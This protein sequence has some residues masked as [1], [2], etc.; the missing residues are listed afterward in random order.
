[1]PNIQKRMQILTV[2]NLVVIAV[3]YLPGF[4]GRDYSESTN[5][6]VQVAAI[7]WLF[8]TSLYGLVFGT[9]Q[10][11]ADMRQRHKQ[12]NRELAERQRRLSGN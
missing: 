10:G 11:L 4:V 1:M 12:E 9:R 8:G 7:V 5:R 2:I 3:A 6:Y